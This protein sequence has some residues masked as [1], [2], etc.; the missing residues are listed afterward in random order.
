MLSIVLCCFTLQFAALI[1][2]LTHGIDQKFIRIPRKPDKL[3]YHIGDRRK[4]NSLQREHTAPWP[5]IFDGV[6]K[7]AW[8]CLSTGRRYCSCQLAI[9]IK[10]QPLEGGLDFIAH[11]F[12]PDYIYCSQTRLIAVAPVP[13]PSHQAAYAMQNKARNACLEYLV[14]NN[15][16]SLPKQL[17]PRDLVPAAI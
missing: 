2:Q 12:T 1:L 10:K 11:C 14:L 9:L 6:N 7:S 15:R 16:G 5:G 4:L 13:F 3:C 8:H 17:P